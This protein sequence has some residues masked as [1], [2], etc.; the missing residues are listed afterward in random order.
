MQFSERI[1]GFCGAN[2][3]GKTNLLDAIYSLCISKGYFGRSDIANMQ[4]GKEGFRVEGNFSKN[5]HSFTVVLIMRE[6]SKKELKVNDELCSRFSDHIGKFPVVVI[7]PDD[8]ILINGGSEDRRKMLDTLMSQVYPDY[9]QLLIR[10]NKILQHRNSLLKQINESQQRDDSLLDILDNQLVETGTSIFSIRK[11]FLAEF[12]PD[13]RAGY[14]RLAGLEEKI[15]LQYSSQLSETNF[16]RLLKDNRERD[17]LSTRTSVGIHKDDILFQLYDQPFRQVGSQGQRKSILFALKLAEFNALK[18]HNDFPPLLL[19]DDVFEKLDEDRMQH[20]LKWA[21][22]ENK[23]QVFLTD[24]H[25]NRLRKALSDLDINF[26]I[27]ELS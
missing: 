23:G 4:F 13:V 16:S 25:A 6:T 26:Q 15:T 5:G 14:Q 20:L 10:Y 12:L 21:C 11:K 19:L 7:A 2:G 27:E 3:I 8:V 1:I 24:T 22:V 17:L 9:L 18:K